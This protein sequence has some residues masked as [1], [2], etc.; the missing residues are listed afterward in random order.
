MAK[1]PLR[2]LSFQLQELVSQGF[3]SVR[4]PPIARPQGFDEGVGSVSLL[5]ELA[6]LRAHLVEGTGG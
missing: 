6:Q 3:R 2:G 4:H 1:A 5:S